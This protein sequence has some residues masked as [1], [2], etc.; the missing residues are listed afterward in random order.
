[1]KFIDSFRFMSDSLS[2]PADNLSDGFYNDKCIDCK[3]HLDCISNMIRCFE[4][5]KKNYKKDFSKDLIKKFAMMEA[6]WWGNW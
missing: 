5:K 1:M 6:R 2:A 3:S 4:C